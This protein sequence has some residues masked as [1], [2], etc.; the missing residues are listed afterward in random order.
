MDNTFEILDQYSNYM[1]AVLGR[2]ELTVMEY[3]Y[4]IICF[5]RFWKRDR[6]KVPKDTPIEEIDVSDITVKDINRRPDI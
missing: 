5:F 1:L 6:R 2:S 4:D 3:K